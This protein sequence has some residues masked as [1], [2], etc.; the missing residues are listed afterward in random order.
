MAALL[1]AQFFSPARIIMIDID[2][3][4]L[5][6]AKKFGATDTINSGKLNAP[7]EIKGKMTEDGVDV[8]IEAVGMPATFDICQRI[9]RP[10]GHIANIG[11]HGKPV[12]FEIDRLWA[13]NITLTAGIV[14]MVS[15]PMLSSCCQSKKLD[16]SQLITHHFSLD[17]G[18]KAYEVFRNAAKENAMKIII[19]V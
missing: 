1:T 11:V 17:E 7:K 12:N 19:S 9:V 2:E 15:V 13:D 5:E 10:G 14:N 18:V 4:R 6:L 3:N 8:A 16:P